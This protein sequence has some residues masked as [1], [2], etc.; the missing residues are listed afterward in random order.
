MYEVKQYNMVQFQHTP[1]R[2]GLGNI[3]NPMIVMILLLKAIWQN[4]VLNETYSIAYNCI[5]EHIWWVK[6]DLSMQLLFTLFE[7]MQHF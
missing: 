5:I 2:D 4:E 1:C 6:I 7:E 3:T